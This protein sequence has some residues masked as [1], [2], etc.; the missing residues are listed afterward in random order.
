M[1]AQAGTKRAVVLR[2]CSPI[3]P[4]ELRSAV[5]NYDRR[6]WSILAW[7]CARQI[8]ILLHMLTAARVQARLR[9]FSHMQK[10]SLVI[11]VRTRFGHVEFFEF[12]PDSDEHIC[13]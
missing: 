4:F 12:C 5:R 7:I 8:G 11:G 10:K 3:S 9:T 2:T 6:R 1:L 13:A